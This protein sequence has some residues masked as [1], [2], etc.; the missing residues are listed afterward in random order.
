MFHRLIKYIVR[1]SI[2]N[3]KHAQIDV[4]FL[5]NKKKIK[6]RNN[7]INSFKS[8]EIFPVL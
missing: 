6:K 7:G 2:I 1:Y 4:K 3:I 5:N 8:F